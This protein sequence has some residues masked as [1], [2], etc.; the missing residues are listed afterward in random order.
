MSLDKEVGAG[1]NRRSVGRGKAGLLPLKSYPMCFLGQV[2]ARYLI[3]INTA[4]TSPFQ[5]GVAASMSIRCHS[6]IFLVRK[7]CES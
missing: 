1:Q 6:I 3:Q 4:C 2:R 5:V 7:K